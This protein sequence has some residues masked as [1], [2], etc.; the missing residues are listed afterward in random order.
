MNVE[1]DQN[2]LFGIVE[3]SILSDLSLEKLEFKEGMCKSL[4]GLIDI[5]L[6]CDSHS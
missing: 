1:F 4:F 6:I 5:F 3:N 2:P